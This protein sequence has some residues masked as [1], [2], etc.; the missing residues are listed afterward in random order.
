MTYKV[1]LVHKVDNRLRAKKAI[2]VTANDE[3]GAK[4]S[5]LEFASSGQGIFSTMVEGEHTVEVEKVEC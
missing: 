5:A 4:K 3:E 2:H 1:Y